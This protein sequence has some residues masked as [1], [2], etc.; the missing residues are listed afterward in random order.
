MAE[1]ETEEQQVEALKNWWKEN[2]TAVMIGVVLG[3]GALGGWRGWDWYQEKQAVNASDIFVSVQRTMIAGDAAS[4]RDE[5]EILRTEYAS[6]PYAALTTL[7]EAKAQAEEGDLEASA[8]SLRWVI[9]HSGQPSIRDIAR[10][11]LARVLLADQKLDD[12][13]AAINQEFS[14]GFSSLVHEIR[15]DILVARGEIEQ[16]K[17]AYDLALDSVHASGVEFLQMKR[18]DLGG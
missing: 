11:R 8:K 14:E 13:Q 2:G 15:G 16:A 10:I 18:D 17:Q 7:H 1:F 5:A 9:E 6:T 12:A 3:I 4:F